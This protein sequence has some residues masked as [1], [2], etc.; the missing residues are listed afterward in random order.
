MWATH[1]AWPKF[2]L[3]LNKNKQKRRQKP[4]PH[5]LFIISL[6]FWLHS[7]ASEKQCSYSFLFPHWPFSPQP[8]TAGLLPRHLPSI[9]L[10]NVSG[11]LWIAQFSEDVL[12]LCLFVPLTATTNIIDH[13][14]YSKCFL[15]WHLFTMASSLGL[16]KSLAATSLHYLS[17]WCHIIF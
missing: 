9:T 17:L 11:N 4:Q 3:S 1:C 13:S 14:S 10:A 12:V 15:A 7:K 5:I 2:C 8:T 6:V 16:P